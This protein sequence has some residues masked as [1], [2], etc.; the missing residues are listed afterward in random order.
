MIY[1]FV[2]R[3]VFCYIL[4]IDLSLLFNWRYT[5]LGSL[6]HVQAT[7][8]Y[9]TANAGFVHSFQLIDVPDFEVSERVDLSVS[10]VLHFF[11]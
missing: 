10:I 11:Y 3:F 5:D 6:E 8:A 4:L 7:P 2:E 9:K 1:H